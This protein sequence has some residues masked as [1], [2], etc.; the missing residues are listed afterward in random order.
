MSQLGHL[1]TRIAAVHTFAPGAVS[2][3]PQTPADDTSDSERA[4]RFS[5]RCPWSSAHVFWHELS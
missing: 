5:E 2:L 4:E 3:S 1:R